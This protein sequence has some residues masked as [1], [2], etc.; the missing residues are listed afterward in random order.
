MAIIDAVE[1]AWYR[2]RYPVPI[3][4]GKYTYTESNVIMATVHDRDG[5][6]GFGWVSGNAIVYQAVRDLAPLV[7]GDSSDHL[8]RIHDR[9]YQPKLIGRK[10]LTTRA[11]SAL[12]IALWDHFAKRL[13]VTVHA[14]VGGFRDRVPAFAAGG[15]YQPGKGLKELG[16]E[17]A[18]YV[19]QGAR[20]VK[21]KIGA[22]TLAEDL[23]RVQAVRDAVGEDIDILVD[24]NGA[25]RTDVARQMARRLAPLGIFWFEEPLSPE[26]LDGYRLL[27][28]DGA[29]PI[30][31]GENEYTRFGF[32][33]LV[34]GHTVDILNADAQVLGGV[35]EWRK[36]A[37]LADAYE[38]PIAPHGNQELHLPLVAGVR[39]GLVVEYYHENV[40]GVMQEMLA[41]RLPLNPD[42]TVSVPHRP[43]FGVLLDP[44]VLAH[45]RVDQTVIRPA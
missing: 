21:M 5:G 45:Y 43:G 41:E 12:D 6:S 9:L 11:V 3:A 40:V 26:N 4:N 1:V 19:A 13:E 36:V 31:H 44:A 27:V 37:A 22:L 10:G 42:G 32:R 28:H 14:L 15:Y 35:T 23:R 8:E 20:A 29:V 25:Y 18:G 16:D 38:I 30:A 7:V 17:M 34:V 24:A 2:S 33:D 39:G